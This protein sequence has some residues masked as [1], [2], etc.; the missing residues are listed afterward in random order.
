MLCLGHRVALTGEDARRHMAASLFQCERFREMVSGFLEEEGGDLERVKLRVKAYEYD[1][2]P[3][4][5]QAEPAY[6][7]NLDARVRAI[8]RLGRAEN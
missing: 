4:P 5:K 1:G 2:K 7:L 8:A 6:L 3:G